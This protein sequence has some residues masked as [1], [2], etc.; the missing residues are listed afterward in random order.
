[1]CLTVEQAAR[2]LDVTRDEAAG[3]LAALEFE[4]LVVH[5]KRRRYRS[6]SPLLSSGQSASCPPAGGRSASPAEIAAAALTQSRAPRALPAAVLEA[7]ALWL[8]ACGIS[9]IPWS[10]SGGSRERWFVREI[11]ALGSLLDD[12]PGHS[13]CLYA[14]SCTQRLFWCTS[15]RSVRRHSRSPSG[16]GRSHECLHLLVVTGESR[17]RA[18]C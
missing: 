1:M 16:I 7:P 6:T 10:S 3:L 18:L 14:S 17:W 5:G 2:L 4:G 11:G 12:S 9:S 8:S 13:Y 15:P